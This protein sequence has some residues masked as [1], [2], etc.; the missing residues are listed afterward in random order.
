MAVSKGIS[1][2]PTFILDGEDLFSG[3]RRPEVIAAYL[4]EAVAHAN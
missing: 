3:A 4:T 2:V 1:G